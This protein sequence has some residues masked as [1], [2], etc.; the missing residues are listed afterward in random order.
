MVSNSMKG[1]PEEAISIYAS[2][3]IESKLSTSK[4]KIISLKYYILYKSEEEP[5]HIILLMHF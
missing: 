1:M 4:A 2:K 3:G 5:I